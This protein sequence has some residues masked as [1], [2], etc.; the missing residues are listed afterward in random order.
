MWT[1]EEDRILIQAHKEVGN[2]WAEIA[3]RLPGRTENSIKNHWNATKRR[4]FARR[5][6]RTKWPRPSSLLQNYIKT[7]NFDQKGPKNPKVVETL[8][9]NSTAAH[10]PPKQ[11]SIEFFSG[12][13]VVPDYDF[14]EV[15][16]FSFDEKLFEASTSIDSFMDNLPP[17]AADPGRPFI[18]HDHHDDDDEKGFCSSK[19]PNDQLMPCEVKKELDLMEMISDHVINL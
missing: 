13:L 10:P 3:K 5:K 1:E 16:E 6:C 8:S 18:D 19:M 11:E 9:L 2:K 4:Q 15:P 12:D 7:F 14:S 17:P